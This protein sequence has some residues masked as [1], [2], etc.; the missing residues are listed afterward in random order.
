MV[1]KIKIRILNNK[2]VIGTAPDQ[3]HFY[4]RHKSKTIIY[5]IHF[6]IKNIIYSA[7][8]AINAEF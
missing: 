2:K 7:N 5:N 6:L 3:F 4:H 8:S 1:A